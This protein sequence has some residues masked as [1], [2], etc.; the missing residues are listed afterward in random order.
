M[1]LSP[2]RLSGPPT[3][4]PFNCKGVVLLDSLY[5]RADFPF[6]TQVLHKNRHPSSQTS[7]GKGAS[8]S[9]YPRFS[10]PPCHSPDLINSAE[11][12][13][14]AKK[15]KKTLTGKHTSGKESWDLQDQAAL[16]RR[17]E[18]FQRENHIERQKWVGNGQSS[19]HHGN[20][21]AHQDMFFSASPS[22]NWDEPENAIVNV[23]QACQSGCRFLICN[24][25]PCNTRLSETVR[26][27]SR[28]IFALHL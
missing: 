23:F 10:N 20:S 2:R 1:T 27:S 18:R 7:S 22:G 12:T 17:A 15:H 16:N 4:K 3:G 9:I 25:R 5:L 8:S 13:S 26:S 28:I 24:R 6:P 21:N 11:S 14:P 19:F